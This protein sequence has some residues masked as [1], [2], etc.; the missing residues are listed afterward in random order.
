MSTPAKTTQLTPEQ[1]A[2]IKANQEAANKQI[3]A[4]AASVGEDK[5]KKLKPFLFSVAYTAADQKKVFSTKALTELTTTALTKAAPDKFLQEFAGYY[6]REEV[7]TPLSRQEAILAKFEAYQAERAAKKAELDAQTEKNKAQREAN[8]LAQAEKAAKIAQERAEKDAKL[9]PEQ[10]A[11]QAKARQISALATEAVK[12]V[13]GKA[14][15]K[16]VAEVTKY[17]YTQPEVNADSL[18]AAFRAGTTKQVEKK[19][20]LE[21]PSMS[22]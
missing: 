19:K 6:K 21:V 5:I 12:R 2:Q 4:V 3:A 7:R 15:P 20:K 9:T 17:A 8:K 18:E 14:D 10:R 11:Q 13:A 1:Q 22:I 16:D